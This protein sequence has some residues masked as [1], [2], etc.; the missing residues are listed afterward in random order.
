[1][2]P[3]LWC[4]PWNQQRDGLITHPMGCGQ[5]FPIRGR[6]VDTARLQWLFLSSSLLLRNWQQLVV[7][8]HLCVCVCDEGW[9][10]CEARIYGDLDK[11]LKEEIKKKKS[12]IKY[13]NMAYGFDITCRSSQQTLNIFNVHIWLLTQH[14]CTLS[15][16]I[17]P[18]NK[19]KT[20]CF[21]NSFLTKQLT[22]VG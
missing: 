1:M 18:L 13:T 21:P 7:T 6:Q 14:C 10:W 12:E 3:T 16:L 8:L 20:Q 4:G 17:H 9:E 15:P 19:Y 11:V 5:L 2:L 22:V